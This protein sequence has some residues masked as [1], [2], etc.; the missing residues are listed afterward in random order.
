MVWDADSKAWLLPH[1]S[2]SGDRVEEAEGKKR[3][4]LSTSLSPQLTLP[5]LKQARGSRDR[6]AEGPS[7]SPS[8]TEVLYSQLKP[9]DPRECGRGV[10]G[11]PEFR[12]GEL[13]ASGQ[14][15]PKKTEMK[16]GARAQP[17]TPRSVAQLPRQGTDPPPTSRGASARVPIPQGRPASSVRPRLFTTYRLS[18][19]SHCVPATAPMR[20]HHSAPRC[21]YLAP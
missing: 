9:G 11:A 7:L 17:T 13:G 10:E 12:K 6:M 21:P 18:P 19:R 1:A 20:G 3:C 4:S 16:A 15:Q 5:F 14:G 2:V 8:Q